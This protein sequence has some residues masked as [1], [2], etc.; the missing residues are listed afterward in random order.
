M[1]FIK[2]MQVRIKLTC[3]SDDDKVIDTVTDGL[4]SKR[5]ALLKIEYSGKGEMPKGNTSV[6][7]HE[8]DGLRISVKRDGESPLTVVGENGE[9]SIRIGYGGYYMSGVI[10]GISARISSCGSGHICRADIKYTMKIG[11]VT[12]RIRQ[13]MEITKS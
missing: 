13:I 1:E 10:D 2:D 5:G 4:F 3:Y 8:D 6:V 9:G 11:N 7:L 12:N